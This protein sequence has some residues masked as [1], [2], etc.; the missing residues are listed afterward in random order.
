MVLSCVFGGFVLEKL[1]LC[2][3]VLKV[4]RRREMFFFCVREDG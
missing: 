3:V 1:N 4:L 2:E